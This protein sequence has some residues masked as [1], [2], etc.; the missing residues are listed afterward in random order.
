MKKNVNEIISIIRV[1]PAMY[2][3]KC[4][5]TLLHSLLVGYAW[6]MEDC[7]GLDNISPPLWQLTCH[8][9]H[10]YRIL[11]SLDWRGLLLLIKNGNEE[12]AL[13]LFWEEWDDFIAEPCTCPQSHWEGHKIV[14]RYCRSTLLSEYPLSEHKRTENRENKNC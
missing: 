14:W 12:E 2:L 6:A 11:D 7:T 8:L 10:K 13:S 1:R 9:S 5:I 3:G 4:S